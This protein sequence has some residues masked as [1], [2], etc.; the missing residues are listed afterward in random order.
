MSEDYLAFLHDA[1]SEN[2][3]RLREILG[4]SQAAAVFN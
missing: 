3:V 1:F 4:E 2:Q